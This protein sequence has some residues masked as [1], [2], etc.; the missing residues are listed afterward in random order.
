M[1]DYRTIISESWP[2]VKREAR[3]RRR[4]R[5]WLAVGAVVLPVVL[6]GVI[7]LNFQNTPPKGVA[8]NSEMPVNEPQEKLSL[9]YELSEAR[10]LEELADQGPILIELE[11]GTKKLI[12][13]RPE[14]LQL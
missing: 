9:T 6:V 12:L 3:R 5:E 13:T 4:K 1:K 7:M 8:K 2:V 14:R 11:D 10:L